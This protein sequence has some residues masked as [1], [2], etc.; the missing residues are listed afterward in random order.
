MAQQ[1]ILKAV[2]VATTDTFIVTDDVG[3]G[4]TTN[5][6][7]TLFPNVL[8]LLSDFLNDGNPN[9]AS[10]YLNTSN[11]VVVVCVGNAVSITGT[12]AATMGFT[13]SET[14]SGSN[15]FNELPTEMFR[16][17]EGADGNLSGVSYTARKRVNKMWP[18]ESAT[19]AIE[20]ANS[21]T[22]AQAAR[23]FTKVIHDARQM[24]LAQ[25]G[26]SNVYCKGVYYLPDVSVYHGAGTLPS[27][28]NSGSVTGDYVFCSAGPPTVSGASDTTQRA[29]YDISLDLT[30]GV[31][32]YTWDIS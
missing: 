9:V 14:P 8:A 21:A 4:Q 16:G 20:L 24:V 32:A 10:I 18:W 13:G 7:Q 31:A 25:S 30:T 27:T 28:W 1:A 3:G 2:E 29:Y 5:P 6:S 17:S 11:K 22:A 19:N 23:S 12:L 26:S 15:M